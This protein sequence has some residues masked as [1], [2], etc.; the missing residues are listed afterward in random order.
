M[1]NDEKVMHHHQ[2]KGSKI[3]EVVIDHWAEEEQTNWNVFYTQKT[4]AK[5]REETEQCR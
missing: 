1:T 5:D 2:R 3:D 4:L